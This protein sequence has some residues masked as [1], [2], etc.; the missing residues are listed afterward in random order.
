MDNVCERAAALAGGGL[1]ERKYAQGGVTFALS[2]GEVQ[3]DW[4]W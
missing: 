4:S 2:L 1:L 3:L